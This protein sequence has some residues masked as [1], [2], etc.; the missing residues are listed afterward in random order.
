MLNE[1]ANNRRGPFRTQRVDPITAVREDV[2][3]LLGDVALLAN[4]AIEDADVFE[5]W[6]DDQF[7]AI[8]VGELREG[9]DDA[10][11]L[12]RRGRQD[13]VSPDGGLKRCDGVTHEFLFC[14]GS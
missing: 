6:R 8:A 1:G 3:L 5:H 2:H 12:G 4:T 11:P 10:F 14:P 9:R 7:E 13:V